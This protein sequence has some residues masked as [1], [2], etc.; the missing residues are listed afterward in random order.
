[1]PISGTSGSGI[2]EG[3][4]PTAIQAFLSMSQHLFSVATRGHP[5]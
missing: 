2:I 1:M 3:S 4:I 5:G